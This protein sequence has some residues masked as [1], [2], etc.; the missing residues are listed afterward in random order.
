MRNMSLPNANTTMDRE[1]SPGIAVS[2]DFPYVPE[3]MPRRF[4]LRGSGRIFLL[5][6]GLVVVL[7]V[8]AFSGISQ[9]TPTRQRAPKDPAML[10]AAAEN[11]GTASLTPILDIGTP[12]AS[13]SASDLAT[14][15]QIERPPIAKPRPL[16]AT[17]L[18]TVPRFEDT[19]QPPPYPVPGQP[20]PGTTPPEVPKREQPRIPPSDQNSLIFV[21]KAVL[22]SP[23]TARSAAPSQR[24]FR[25]SPGTRLRARLESE[26]NSAVKT[27]V[28]AVIEDNY[29]EHGRLAI[30]AG[31]RVIGRL[32]NA[33]R[34]GFV[35]I[36]FDSLEMA[37]DSSLEIRA[38]ATDLDFRPLR[39]R[40][41][42]RATG[43]NLLM[44]SVTGIGEV[45][46]TLVGRG[47]LN[48][49]LSEQD[50]LR[51]RL[52]N[53]I[54][55]AGDQQIAALAA[56]QLFVVSVPAASEIYVVFEKEG[57]LPIQKNLSAADADAQKIE[58]PS[59][60]PLGV[61]QLSQ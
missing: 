23:L 55:Q 2:P 35:E 11:D 61:N 33:D 42:G 48:Q 13:S 26:I 1:S 9:K 56:S 7:L 22:N 38:T 57:T 28:V 60:L 15:D 37:S 52:S 19:W 27:P 45:A 6:A 20:E 24:S 46:A 21:S 3:R 39:G 30:P 12:A 31:S 25:L 41:K 36:D 49:P 29:E 34:S 5:G 40:V 59:K 16:H 18:A 4:E 10:N 58:N 43:K 44:R 54:G 51:E 32:V 8:L 53:N 17:T 14:P 50:L 47:S